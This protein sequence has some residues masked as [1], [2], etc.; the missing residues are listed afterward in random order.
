M[1]SMRIQNA[2]K[3]KNIRKNDICFCIEDIKFRSK[4]LTL[5]QS[6]VGDFQRL[7]ENVTINRTM[8]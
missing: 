1:I 5:W 2:K 4:P 3:N 6:C 8:M 7:N